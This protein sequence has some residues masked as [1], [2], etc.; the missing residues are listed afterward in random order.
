MKN[1]LNTSDISRSFGDFIRRF[2]IILF[3]LVVSGGLFVAILMLLSIIALSSSTAT[4]SDQTINGSFDDATIQRLEQDVGKET[5]P[6]G[7]SSPFVE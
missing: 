5:T 4:S 1:T 7:R 6:N 3:F 2:H